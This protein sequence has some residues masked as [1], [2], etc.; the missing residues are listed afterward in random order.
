MMSLFLLVHGSVQSAEG[1]KL[2]I[3]ELEKRGHMTLTTNLPTTDPQASATRYADVIV[4]SID[5]TDYDLRDMVVVAHS[6]S[7]MFLPLVAAQR[8]IGH[9][10]FLAALVP[11][12]GVSILEQF[13]ADQSMFNPEWVGKNP[14]EDDDAARR[15]LFHDCAP[16]VI[17]WAMKSRRLMNARAAMSEVC[18]LKTWPNV[19]GSYVVCSEDRVLSPAWSRRIAKERLGNEPI[20]LLSGHC[21][22]VSHPSE[23]A[24]ALSRAPIVKS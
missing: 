13:R 3:P 11:K 23:L 10:V 12:I 7:G 15:F 16:G 21:P 6:A 24:D 5:Q 4:Q 1:W 22:Y 19:K 8:P 18:P 20:E 14:V 9:M 2:L 17:D